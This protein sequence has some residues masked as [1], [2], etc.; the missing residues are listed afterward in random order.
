M[1]TLITVA[2]VN[3]RLRLGMDVY[4]ASGDPLDTDDI[5]SEE[6]PRVLKAMDEAESIVLDYIDQ[7]DD[8]FGTSPPAYSAQQLDVIKSAI[9]LLIQAALDDP[10][11]RTAGDYMK[12]NEGAVPLLLMRLR[13]PTVA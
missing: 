8:N 5:D 6:L 12:T 7:R 10:D 3:D 13:R 11:G 2:E 1:A 9:L 4:D